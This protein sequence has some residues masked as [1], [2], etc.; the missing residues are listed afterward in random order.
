[1]L[2]RFEG[3]LLAHIEQFFPTHWRVIGAKQM[4]EVVRFGVQRARQLGYTTERDGYLFH[5]LMLQFGSYFDTDPQYPWLAKTLADE[6][7]GSR[8]ERLAN[9]HD[10]AVEFLDCVVGPE[11]EHMTLALRRAHAMV[12]PDLRRERKIGFQSVLS[13]L[14]SMWPQKFERVGERAVRELAQSAIPAVESLG[15]NSGASAWLY[16]VACFL[17]G[18][19]MDRDPQFPWVAG[20]LRIGERRDAPARSFPDALDMH[21]RALEG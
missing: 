11:G 17:F 6:A 19:G 16:V 15:L 13:I 4:A 20:L 9:A 10:A 8:S 18:H 12:V 21:L 3:R 7:V 1:M 5:S 2:D 14:S